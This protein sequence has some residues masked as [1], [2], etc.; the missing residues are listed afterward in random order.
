[1]NGNNGRDE[2]DVLYIA[3]PGKDAVPGPDGA[4][5]DAGSFD[6]FES[7]IQ[8]LGDKLVQRIGGASASTTGAPAPVSTSGANRAR[9]FKAIW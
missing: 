9:G 5:W 6:E 3:F 4:K 1:M 2:N 7:S 8:G